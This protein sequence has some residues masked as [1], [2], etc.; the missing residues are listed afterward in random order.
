M[1]ALY[2]LASYP[3]SGNTWFR[4]FLCNLLSA[5]EQPV[6]INELGSGVI[7]SSRRW[8]DDALG[9]DSAELYPD[10]VDGLRP[11]VYRWKAQHEA[12]AYHKIHDA[13]LPNAA[14]ELIPAPDAAAG[15][16]YIVRNPLDVAPSLANHLGRS[17]D[18]A[19]DFMASAESGLG[20][21]RRGFSLQVAQRLSSW[22][23]HV[24]SWLDGAGPRLLVIRYEDMLADGPATF[25]AAARFLGL[26]DD[27]QRIERAIRF[28]D[29]R[30]LAAQE[31]ESGFKERPK[32]AARFFRRGEKG[33][34]R[35]TLGPD[36]VRRVVAAH[37]PMMARFGYLDEALAW[38]EQTA[39]PAQEVMHE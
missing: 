34:W 26:P 25:A 14:G 13:C 9:V 1:S 23:G 20:R 17:L 28:S 27:S 3:K 7:A 4:A 29:F 18:Q 35:D 38:L 19:I 37:G 33:A 11:A 30:L 16:V 36:Q 6:S 22:S 31:G 10:E 39:S 21:S 5:A 2:W 12:L 8:L 15:S 24:Q 32:V